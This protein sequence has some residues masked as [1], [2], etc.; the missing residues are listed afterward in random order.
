[1][2]GAEGL[3]LSLVDTITDSN[4]NSSLNEPLSSLNSSSG[5]SSST[6]LIRVQQ[7]SLALTQ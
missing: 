3:A 1:M 7:L 6:L 2:L 4:G 5:S